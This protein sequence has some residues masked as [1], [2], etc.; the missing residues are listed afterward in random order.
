MYTQKRPL[1]YDIL[2][3]PWEI[4]IGHSVFVLSTT[5]SKW[6]IVLYGDCK[7][8]RTTPVIGKAMVLQQFRHI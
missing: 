2:E 5:P 3:E 4:D 6:E 1:R 7:T 8:H